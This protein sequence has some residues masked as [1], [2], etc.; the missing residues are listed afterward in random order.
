[1]SSKDKILDS[2][3]GLV[4]VRF[5]DRA[6]GQSRSQYKGMHSTTADDSSEWTLE[7]T[8]EHTIAGYLY[9]FHKAIVAILSADSE[10][11]VTVE[12]TVEDIDIEGPHGLEA[13]Q[14]KYHETRSVFTSSTLYKPLLHMMAHYHNRKPQ[15]IRYTI[16]AYFPNK[17]HGTRYNPSKQDL[18][19]AL[20]T[21]NQNLR[22]IAA[23][24][25]GN[26]DLDAFSQICTVEFGPS[27]EQLI[28]QVFAALEENNFPPDDIDILAYPHAINTIAN[29][30]IRRSPAERTIS[31]RQFV[32]TLRAAKQVAITRWVRNTRSKDKILRSKQRELKPYMGLN[33]RCRHFLI[34][35]RTV[36]DFS[37]K[38]VGFLADYK[39][40]YHWKPHHTR[41]PLF[42]LD[43]DELTYQQ[44]LENLHDSKI[45][46]EDG[47]VG[48]IFKREK[49]FSELPPGKHVRVSRFDTDPSVL[50]Y[51]GCDDLFIVSDRPN[52]RSGSSRTNVQILA[53]DRIQE[54]NY[55]LG[56][57]G[58]HE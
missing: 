23:P 55:L 36:T 10:E 28:K 29:L 56:L 11:L 32:G 40:R 45:E 15:D 50:E 42:C 58:N 54:L 17:A 57:A 9:Q 25:Q 34:S 12:G 41:P 47:Y 35:A 1:M 26:I 30:S 33:S 3:A 13:I 27:Y 5:R 31:R 48:T 7:R 6:L 8:A 37:N 52:V 16:F 51:A 21:K 46:F 53:V 49:L 43:C 2:G 19:E 18:Q 24:L 20:N 4:G 14:C 22:R 44:I 39:G 38:I